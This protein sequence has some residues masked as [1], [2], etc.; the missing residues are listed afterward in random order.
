MKAIGNLQK[1][2]LTKFSKNTKLKIK[3]EAS[4]N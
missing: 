4:N 1:K 2:E 3:E